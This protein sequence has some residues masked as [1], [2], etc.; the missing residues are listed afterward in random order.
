[1]LEIGEEDICWVYSATSLGVIAINHTTLNNKKHNQILFYDIDKDCILCEIKP[2]VQSENIYKYNILD[3]ELKIVQDIENSYIY[4]KERYYG[5]IKSCFNKIEYNNKKYNQNQCGI[6]KLYGNNN[7][8]ILFDQN[9]VLYCNKY[10]DNEVLTKEINIYSHNPNAF[11]VGSLLNYNIETGAVFTKVVQDNGE[12]YK[13]TNNEFNIIYFLEAIKCGRYKYAYNKLSYNLKNEI[14]K[15]TLMQYF[16][17]IDE[18]IYLKDKQIYITVKNNKVIG[19]YHFVVKNN[20]IEEI[21]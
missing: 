10:I 11:N 9:K 1:M 17:V 13:Q 2:F 15:Q 6:I 18:Y 21:Y 8:I 4:Y 12:E 14:N 16:N 3:V 7:Y 19:V 20:L 5:C